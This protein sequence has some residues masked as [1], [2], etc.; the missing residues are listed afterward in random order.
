MADAGA[1]AELAEAI[2]ALHYDPAYDRSRKRHDRP[3]LG[4]AAL[5]PHDPASLGAAVDEV[6]RLVAR[7]TPGPRGA[8]LK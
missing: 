4:V 3:L 2:M 8:T 1:F 5:V 7:L 6:V